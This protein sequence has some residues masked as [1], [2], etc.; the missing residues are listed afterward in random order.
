M[1]KYK[2]LT[3]LFCQSITF[4]SHLIHPSFNVYYLLYGRTFNKKYLGFFFFFFFLHT[5]ISL[6]C[7]SMWPVAACSTIGQPTWALWVI[8][9][10]SVPEHCA[11]KWNINLS[12]RQGRWQLTLLGLP[13]TTL[14]WG[15][16][17]CHFYGISGRLPL[18][19]GLGWGNWRK[20][21]F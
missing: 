9:F 1:F 21:I 6:K 11:F 7:P 15:E 4:K 13:E 8:A 12:H 19:P 16:G 3:I 17:Q 2:T 18:E 14:S 5:F 10:A 20:Y